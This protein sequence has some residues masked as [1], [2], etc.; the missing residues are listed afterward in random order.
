MCY[1]LGGGE[2]GLVPVPASTVA[3]PLVLACGQGL[4]STERNLSCRHTGQQWCC[5]LQ[6][7]PRRRRFCRCAI[8][9][10]GP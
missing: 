6:N 10:A 9:F 5:M 8:L 7:F 2:A 4:M 1:V 3:E